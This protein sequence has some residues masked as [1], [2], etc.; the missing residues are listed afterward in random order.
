MLPTMRRACVIALLPLLLAS[1]A[2]TTSRICKRSS[3]LGKLARRKLNRSISAGG[4]NVTNLATKNAQR[5]LSCANSIGN[6]PTPE[7]DSIWRYRFVMAADNRY[8]V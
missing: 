6:N 8:P 7:N 2:L 1:A 3:T 4:R 5:I